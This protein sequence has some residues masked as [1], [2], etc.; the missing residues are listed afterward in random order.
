[1]HR[2]AVAILNWNGRKFLEQFLPSVITHSEGVADIYVIDNAS[3]D[4]SL[5]YLA[6]EYPTVQT[7]ILDKNYGFAGGYNKGLKAIPNEILILLNSDVE[8]TE[9]WIPPV[10]EFMDSQPKMV[11]CQPK[12]LD[13]HRKEY[14]EYAGAA[15]GYV[16]KDGFAFC[17][18]RIFYAFDKDEGQYNE[19][20]EV[21]WASGASLFI[22]REA[23]FEV[24]GLD[25]DFFAHMEEID[26]C[27]RLKNRG[28]Q[29]GSCRKSH[30]YHYGGGTLDRMNPYKTF[31]NFR[32]NLFLILK[33]HRATNVHLKIFRRMILDGIAGVRFI[34]EGNWN[35]FTAVIRAHFSFYGSYRKMNRKRKLEAK[36]DK[37]IN[38]KGLYKGSII[39]EFFIQKKK[40]FK[41]L[42]HRLFAE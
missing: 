32:N 10:L 37:D 6:A 19:N 34:T 18:G 27:W 28:Y 38:L 39:S 15:G 5:A 36:S 31:L 21:F 1:M 3:S 35:Y 25:E 24:D 12:I 14:F 33:N 40:H 26:L 9:N 20:T 2:V 23:Y 22:K 8:V 29:I 11:A 30:V 13:F 7:V 4:D 41:D 17:A 42:D 16:D